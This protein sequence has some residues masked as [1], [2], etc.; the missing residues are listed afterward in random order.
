MPAL[1]IRSCG[2]Q[3]FLWHSTATILGKVASQGTSVSSSVKWRDWNCSM[4]HKKTL[5]QEVWCYS[6]DLCPPD[7]NQSSSTFVY[8]HAE[9]LSPMCQTTG[10]ITCIQGYFRE[11]RT[12]VHPG[13]Q[14][15]RWTVQRQRSGGQ[16]QKGKAVEEAGH[17]WTLREDGLWKDRG[18]RGTR[19]AF[20]ERHSDRPRHTENRTHWG[21]SWAWV[22]EEEVESRIDIRT[23]VLEGK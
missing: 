2:F 4:G 17:G 20:K 12:Y 8:F 10:Q 5:G 14:Q 16:E 9:H 11:A 1:G 6:N 22:A 18:K 21:W 13:Y 7:Y 23:W 19:R 3:L 15:Y